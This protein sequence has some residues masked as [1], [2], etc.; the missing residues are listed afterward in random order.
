MTPDATRRFLMTVCTTAQR[1]GH[2]LIF[3]PLAD[4]GH[5]WEWSN[6]AKGTTDA[7]TAPVAF[8]HACCDYVDHQN[9]AGNFNHMTKDKQ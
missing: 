9:I 2:G 8:Y 4:G 1:A 3:T 5:S 7:G 6:G